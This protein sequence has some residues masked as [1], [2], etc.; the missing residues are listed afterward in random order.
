LDNNNTNVNVKEDILKKS[1]NEDEWEIISDQSICILENEDEEV[2]IKEL[3]KFEF[4]K[5]YFS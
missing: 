1:F 2:I 5:N 3:N 4:N